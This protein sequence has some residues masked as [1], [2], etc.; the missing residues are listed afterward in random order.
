[1]PENI[2][3]IRINALKSIRKQVGKKCQL[4]GKI[5]TT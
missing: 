5:S 2:H 1:M 3:I 4:L